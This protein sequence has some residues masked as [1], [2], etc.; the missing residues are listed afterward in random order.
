MNNT[1][2]NI[3]YKTISME[4]EI[5]DGIS[6]QVRRLK[7]TVSIDTA[8][9]ILYKLYKDDY[10]GL[11]YNLWV[12]NELYLSLEQGIDMNA[13]DQAKLVAAGYIIIQR[14]DEP[15][16]HVKCKS[17]NN[18]NSWKKFKSKDERDCQANKLFKKEEK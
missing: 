8:V 17:E 3:S 16:P 13:K 10:L 7:E 1:I 15:E 11:T 6:S 18:P 14:Q 5:T 9:F 12:D 4:I 2:A